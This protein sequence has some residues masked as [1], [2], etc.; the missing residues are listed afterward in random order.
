M[1][2]PKETEK[3]PFYLHGKLN[4]C[5]HFGAFKD[6]NAKQTKTKRETLRFGFVLSCINLPFLRVGKKV[7][8][9]YMNDRGRRATM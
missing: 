2:R 9:A 7:V 8:R 5:W 4:Y 1:D 3:G 6:K